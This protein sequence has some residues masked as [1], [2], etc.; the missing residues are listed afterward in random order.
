[1]KKSIVFIA[2]LAIICCGLAQSDCEVPPGDYKIGVVLFKHSISNANMA[3][4]LD[5][6]KSQVTS[7]LPVRSSNGVTVR[8]VVQ[9][10]VRWDETESIP[11]VYDF[12]W[13]Q[14]FVRHCEQKEIKWT[15]LLSPHYL[16]E[17]IPNRYEEDSIRLTNG[18]ALPNA[19][20]PMS[21]SSKMWRIEVRDWAE[22][23]LNKMKNDAGMN[24]FGPTGAID[25]I[26]IGNAMTYPGGGAFVV[27]S[28]D[29]ATVNTWDSIYQTPMP[30]SGQQ[31]MEFRGAELARMLRDLV[32]CTESKLQ[33]LGEQQIKVST[34]VSPYL[35]PRPSWTFLDELKGYTPAGVD[36]I[37]ASSDILAINSMPKPD[38]G[39]GCVNFWKVRD[40]YTA[41]NAITPK[42]IYVAEYNVD[43]ACGIS[44]PGTMVYDH[45]LLGIDSFNVKYFTFFAWNPFEPIFQIKPDQISALRNVFDCL[46]NP[47]TGT[48]ETWNPDWIEVYPNPTVDGCSI[49]NRSEKSLALK[50]SLSNGWGETIQN[51]PLLLKPHAQYELNLQHYPSG[52]Y[53]FRLESKWG[54]LFRK[55]AILDPN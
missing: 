52:I 11:E 50:I 17:W 29:S 44:M 19:F 48:D 25:E 40:D 14:Q 45:I 36:T 27:T 4:I 49:V 39:G 7:N 5:N 6:I 15:P 55:L 26:F 37:V 54:V 8:L 20:M 21:P 32:G 2:M 22:A 47:Q 30:T 18:N 13:Y 12:S 33:S 38:S 46:V 16:P 24:H 28:F 51:F 35:F 1:M 3:T 34:K 53:Y 42:P 23:F 43:P 31:F 41:A 10:E 9:L